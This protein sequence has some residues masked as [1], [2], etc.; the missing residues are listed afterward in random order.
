M[1]ATF[2]PVKN[3][4]VENSPFA[5][6]IE[7]FNGDG[8]IDLVAA[9]AGSGSVSVLLGDDNGSFSPAKN[10]EVGNKPVSVTVGD[11][12]GDGISDLAT[13]NELSD[14]VSVLLLRTR[15]PLERLRF[16]DF[17]GDGKTDVFI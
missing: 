10:I 17:N 6:A 11:F 3:F 14:N 1:T 8:N 16:G 9:N 4:D 5:I 7:D 12:N 2:N 15:I 13:A